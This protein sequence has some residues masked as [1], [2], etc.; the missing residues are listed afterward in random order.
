MADGLPN[1]GSPPSSADK[2][3]HQDNQHLVV[4]STDTTTTTP[5][6]NATNSSDTAAKPV[7]VAK[8]VSKS[9]GVQASKWASVPSTPSKPSFNRSSSPSSGSVSK[10]SSEGQGTASS[11]WATTGSTSNYRS[12]FDHEPRFNRNPYEGRLNRDSYDGR[13]NRSTVEGRLNRSTVEGR[14]N[15][16]SFDGRLNRSS[17]EGRLN[18]DTI[19]GRLNRDALVDHEQPSWRSHPDRESRPLNKEDSR[20]ERGVG[21]EPSEPVQ[22]NDE[23]DTWRA[24]P[25]R[26]NH[27]TQE[28]TADRIHGVHHETLA[29][30]DDTQ[31]TQARRPSATN[32]STV[33]QSPSGTGVD[34][35]KDGAGQSLEKLKDLSL[36]ANAKRPSQDD[37]LKSNHIP[38]QQKGPDAKPNVTSP[39]TYDIPPGHLNWADMLE[40]DD[41]EL[42]IT[43][44]DDEPIKE[45]SAPHEPAVASQ[46]M[47]EPDTTAEA[48][49]PVEPETTAE[50]EATVD[51]LDKVV[52]E[53][54]KAAQLSD[55]IVEE[56]ATPVQKPEITSKE[57]ETM[58]GPEKPAEQLQGIQ[59]KPV[60]VVDSVGTASDSEAIDPSKTVAEPETVMEASA[61]VVHETASPPV[62]QGEKPVHK[63]PPAWQQQLPVPQQDHANEWKQLAEAARRQDHTPTSL[64]KTSSVSP[65]SSSTTAPSQPDSVRSWHDF[66]AAAAAKREMK[67]EHYPS[68]TMQTPQPSPKPVNVQ[69]EMKRAPPPSPITNT[70]ESS[71]RSG[72]APAPPPVPVPAAKQHHWD[73]SL[74]PAVPQEGSPTLSVSAGHPVIRLVETQNDEPSSLQW[75]TMDMSKQTEKTQSAGNTA[76]DDIEEQWK[77]TQQ[78]GWGSVPAVS[79]P[80]PSAPPTTHRPMHESTRMPV[81]ST[82]QTGGFY[83]HEETPTS[84]PRQ[85][86]RIQM[87]NHFKQLERLV[88]K[89]ARDNSS[90]TRG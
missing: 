79:E 22:R 10:W 64:P 37:T 48:E 26:P 72:T 18:R 8:P 28:T 82:P 56:A 89:A 5:P 55:Q 23:P 40:D 3:T 42:E 7:A 36:D 21:L 16:D 54:D 43:F 20:W 87:G 46:T 51:Q 69:P 2:V 33:I 52:E 65:V 14:L 19:E 78:L 90:T 76:F 80:M 86:P 84:R 75:N 13:L 60:E 44:D 58:V 81:S 32:R 71:P 59:E 12:H 39:P 77:K 24:R 67:R 4:P 31:V 17:V 34:N 47:A 11:R 9:D 41:E 30:K 88:A 6:D 29:N 38:D 49:T 1:P 85:R 73:A 15:R 70:F 53:P 25:V 83:H 27:V 74:S 50:P 45:A 66:A 57:S 61:T 35:D 68:T 62:H 63:L